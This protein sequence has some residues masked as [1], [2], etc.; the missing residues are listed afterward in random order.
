MTLLMKGKMKRIKGRWM[1]G[2]R[3]REEQKERGR[4][5]ERERRM[6]GK[7]EGREGRRRAT[8]YEN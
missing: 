4:E 2:K 3:E 5:E 7:G 8:K 1:D 6:N